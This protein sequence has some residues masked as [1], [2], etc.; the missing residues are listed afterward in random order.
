MKMQKRIWITPIISIIVTT[1]WGN[2][3]ADVQCDF[4]PVFTRSDEEGAETV[5]V[6]EAKAITLSN[7]KRP[8]LFITSLKVNTDGTK[9]SYHQDDPTGRRCATN[10]SAVPCAINDIRN[11]YVDKSKPVSDFISIRDAGYPS[12]KTW[13]VLNSS[14]IEKSASTNK[15]CIS[16]DGY[17]VSMTAD[18]AVSGGW[19]RVG[20]CDQAKWIDALTSPAIVL[21][22][23][24]SSI[25]SQFLSFGIGKRSLVV[26]LAKSPSHR[27][28]FGIVGDYGPTNEIGEANIAFNRALN[29]LSNNDQPKHRQDAINR[30]QAGTTAI[31]LFPGSEFVLARPISGARIAAAGANAIA[32]F[33][34]TN[35]LVNCIHNE[36]EPSF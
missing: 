2:G 17:L 14:I 18:V 5:K 19:S 27:N 13:Q 20:D 15:P 36:I 35:K 6:Y 9:I 7:G 3:M 29:G 21:P 8:L 4:Q 24:T 31:L 28:V 32:Q 25:P 34:D 11:A 22:K 1:M 10:P 33:G 30:F 23:P 26:G 12:S 16:S